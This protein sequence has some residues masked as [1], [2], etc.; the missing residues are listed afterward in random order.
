MIK[1]VK[2][3]KP[4]ILVEKETQWTDDLM[5]YINN[6]TDPPESVKNKYRHDEIKNGVK[7]E[8][9]GKCAYCESK[10]LHVDYGDIEHIIPKAIK[11]DLS[12]VWGNLTL[13][14][15]K[16]NTNK[17]KKYNPS[18]PFLNPYVDEIDDHLRAFG[19]LISHINHSFCGK[20]TI[21][22]IQLNRMELI[23]RRID[24]LMHIQVIIDNYEKSP[25]GVEKDYLKQELITFSDS[26]KEFSFILKQYLSDKGII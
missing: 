17:S 18:S 7:L 1:L 21:G 10:L 11:P 20:I 8:T 24:A 4:R 6:K 2:R 22:E 16:C 23:E 9:N 3:S 25:A 14:C 5:R 12:F 19:P 13:A 15:S 26:D